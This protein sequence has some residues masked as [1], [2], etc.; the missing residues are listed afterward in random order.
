MDSM[1]TVTNKPVWYIWESLREESL[2]VLT[3]KLTNKRT[4]TLWGDGC[5]NY[6]YCGNH[7]PID[8]IYTYMYIYQNTV[9]YTSNVYNVICQLYLKDEKK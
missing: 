1:V 8:L 2:K 4:V 9:W 6:T 5:V 7:F 3:T